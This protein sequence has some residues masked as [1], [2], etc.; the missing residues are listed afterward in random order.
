[1]N[2]GTSTTKTKR[3][4]KEATISERNERHEIAVES[5]DCLRTGGTWHKES[6]F[7][8]LF[9]SFSTDYQLFADYLK[10]ENIFK[11]KIFF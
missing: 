3:C 6:F 2:E 9:D 8:F 4:R 10:S 1:M 5:H 7:F 11:I